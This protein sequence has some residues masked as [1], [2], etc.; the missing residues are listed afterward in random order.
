MGEVVAGRYELVDA[1]GSGGM[2]TVWRV[3][4]LRDSTYR[5]A[6]LLRQSD[7][8]SLLRFV[9]ETGTRIEHPHVVAP[10]GWSAEDDR[11]LFAMPLIGGGSVAELLADYGPLPASLVRTLTLQLLDALTA[12]HAAGIVHRDVK[13]AN[14]LLEP[15]GIGEPHL[16]LSDFGIAARLDEP[17]LT[18]TSEM[19]H[20]PGYSAPEVV[21]GADPHPV[22][23]L[24]SV[25]MVMQEMLTGTRPEAAD[26]LGPM[27]GGLA[28]VRARLAAADPLARYAS[29]A[30]ARTALLA[31]EVP[32]QDG[33]PIEVFS[34]LPDLPEGWGAEGP[35]TAVALT[36]EP[37]G[38][39]RQPR[40]A[41]ARH[42][43]LAA[44]LAVAGIALLVVAALAL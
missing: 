24:F 8:T 35:G 6:K 20:T 9:R 38:P 37:V 32:E 30:D 3:W 31:I 44:V 42:Y 7:S 4:D 14:L 21:G 2:G 10:T 43:V 19:M 18:R 12:V 15:T 28:G 39:A 16:R 5:A 26:M 29:A 27:S 34:H 17:R 33:E 13:P 1:L 40:S 25:G 23:D 36:P 41:A 22:Q 11:V